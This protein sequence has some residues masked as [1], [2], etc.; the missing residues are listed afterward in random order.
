MQRCITQLIRRLT[1]DNFAEVAML[2]DRMSNQGLH[3]ACVE[4]VLREENRYA[5][6]VCLSSHASHSGS[7][8]LWHRA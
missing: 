8:F 7:D 4:F 5:P 2:A 1:L 6:H 3:K